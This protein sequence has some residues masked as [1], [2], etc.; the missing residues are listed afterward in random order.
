MGKIFVKGNEAVV[1]GALL[2]RCEAFFGYPITPASEI[3]E[4]AA[5]L[6]P[7]T[8]G[9]FLQAESEIAAIN[10][11]YGAASAGK[12]A[13]TAS[14][15]PGISLKQEGISYAAGAELPMVIVDIMR[16]GPGLGN[17]APEQGDYHQM[18]HGGGHG[19]YK[20]I[21]LAPNCA[22]EMCDLTMLAFELSDKY[23]TPAVVLA[24]GFVG[25]MMEPIALPAPVT[26]L[27]AKPW[28]VDGTDATDQNLISS[29]FLEPLEME[30]HI[31]HLQDKYRQISAKEVRCEE[32]ATEDADIILI[33]YG[34]MSRILETVVAQARQA[35]L[36]VGLLR[37]VTLWPFP[38][39][40]IRE[41]SLSTRLF[42]VCEL[43]NGQMVN[44]VRLAL[45]GSRPVHFYGRMGGVVPSTDEI[46]V[47]VEKSYQDLDKTTTRPVAE[48]VEDNCN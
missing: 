23:R 25:Q 13:M 36:K 22:Q 8:G 11:V 39:K 5:L 43:S 32:I 30:R 40:K 20:L 29:I 35:G 19:N 3:A 26:R 21:V 31:L 16:A 44:D 17:I 48:G 9:V 47:Q 18:V 10:M 27:P 15:S 24:D 6:F 38:E 4:A 37:P 33:G 46:L 42:L 41:L 28:A 14:S 45:G 2:A 12:R 7:K 1:K 34:I